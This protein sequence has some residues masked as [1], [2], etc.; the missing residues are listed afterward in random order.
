VYIHAGE[1][2]ERRVAL[3]LKN[4]YFVIASVLFTMSCMVSLHNSLL[5]KTEHSFEIEP[6]SEISFQNVSGDLEVT[7]WDSGFVF[8][9]TL[10]YGDST[11]DIPDDLEISYLEVPEGL[12]ITV[13]HPGGF[14]HYS[15]DF[16]VKVPSNHGLT[17]NHETV[18]GDTDIMGAFIVNV[19]KVSGDTHLE[20]LKAETLVAVSGD[21][22]I[23]LSEQDIALVIET[24]SGDIE[25]TLSGEIGINVD[26]VSGDI[27]INGEEFNDVH[28]P[29]EKGIEAMLD[30]VSGDVTVVRN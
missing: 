23:S 25:A 12:S 15:V 7:E 3:K 27:F 9:E 8:I 18:S 20:V 10:I 2:F 19:E 21:F 17:I 4:N 16:M 6:N 28:I 13:D 11:K 5:E 14:N 30:T 29:S 26:T 1:L 24:V 22:N